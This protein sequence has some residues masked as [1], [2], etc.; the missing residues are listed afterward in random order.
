MHHVE[1]MPDIG[2]FMV[3]DSEDFLYLEDEEGDEPSEKPAS[4]GISFPKI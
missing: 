4:R 1:A 2:R 3:E